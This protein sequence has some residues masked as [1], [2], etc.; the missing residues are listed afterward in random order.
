MK[1]Y[2]IKYRIGSRYYSD[3]DYIEGKDEDDAKKNFLKKYKDVET[4][5]IDEITDADDIYRK[6]GFK[7]R[8]AYLKY[9]GDEYNVDLDE[10][11]AMA[12]VLGRSEDFDGL[13]SALD[14]RLYY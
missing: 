12:E 2:K 9:L 7:D 13:V 10:V 11:F 14:R 5:I 3:K 8:K 6:H 1:V 4:L